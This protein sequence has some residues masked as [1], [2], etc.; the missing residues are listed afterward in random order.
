LPTLAAVDAA[1]APWRET[2]KTRADLV[3]LDYD[4]AP[5]RRPVALP[6]PQRTRP[7]IGGGT[8]PAD[9]SPALRVALASPQLMPSW[10]TAPASEPITATRCIASGHA[11]GRARRR[12]SSPKMCRSRPCFA[13]GIRMKASLKHSELTGARSCAGYDASSVDCDPREA[14]AMASLSTTRIPHSPTD[15]DGQPTDPGLT[16]ELTDNARRLL[17]SAT[18]LHA[19]AGTA[20]ARTA[21]GVLLD[22]DAALRTIADAF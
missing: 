14:S 17:E 12:H 11:T 5:R 7:P 8:D 4:L 2:D 16:A 19:V 22:V 18:A 6:A 21:P 13:P 15:G 9:A 10:T 3:I 1:A 20:D